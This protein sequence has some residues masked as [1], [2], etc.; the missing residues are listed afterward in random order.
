MRLREIIQEAL[1]LS[2]R[3]VIYHHDRLVYHTTNAAAAANILRQGFRTGA[4]LGVNE[5]RKA[6]YAADKDVNPELYSRNDRDTEPYHGQS[7][8]LIPINLKGLRLLNITDGPHPPGTSYSDPE[9]FPFHKAFQAIVNRGDLHRIPPFAEGKIDGVINY[10]DDD[11]IY[12]VCLPADVA[13]L[14]ITAA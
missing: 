9:A 14:A 4:D 1:D 13:T 12:Q 5:R 10:L 6:V 7:T 3:V 2:D 11:R 8:A